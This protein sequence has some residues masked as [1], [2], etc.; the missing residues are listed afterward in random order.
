MGFLAP[1]MLVGAL[2]IGVPIAIHLIG[3]RRARIVPFAALDF[4]MTTKRRTARRLRL[5]ERML[6]IVRA[7]ACLAVAIALAKPFT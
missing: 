4:L 1:V 7:L 6:L 5:R 2:V 3:R